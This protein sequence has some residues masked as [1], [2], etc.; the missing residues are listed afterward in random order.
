EARTPANR[1]YDDS[2]LYPGR[3]KINWNHSYVLEPAG[4]AVGAVVLLHGMTDSPYSLRHIAAEYQARGFIA[5]GVRLP[6]HGTVP[7]GLAAV[8][9]QD[10]L[11]ATRVAIREA[12]RRAGDAV[13]L[14]VVGY[15][16]GAALALS[17]ALD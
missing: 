2:P 4:R 12:R 7:A 8:A 3:F 13:P 16:T 14:H 10:W 5:V 15:S 11:A 1:Y 9:W 6:G 17:Y